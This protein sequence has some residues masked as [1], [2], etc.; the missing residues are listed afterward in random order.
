MASKIYPNSGLRSGRSP[1]GGKSLVGLLGNALFWLILAIAIP[2]A[3]L[4]DEFPQFAEYLAWVPYL[5]YALALISFVRAIRGLSGL[6]AQ[7][8]GRQPQQKSGSKTPLAKGKRAMPA[9][10]KSGLPVT[11]TP[12]VQRMR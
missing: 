7:R 4:Q 5:F 8:T 3:Q 10:S 12:T 11:R 1:T 9:A 2:I 6:F